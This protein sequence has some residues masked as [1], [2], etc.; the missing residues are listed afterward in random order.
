MSAE[1]LESYERSVV[2]EVQR[3]VNREPTWS[4]QLLGGM[5]DRS[6]EVLDIVLRTEWGRRTLRMATE[7]AFGAL[8]GVVLR[9]LADEGEAA[10][11][12]TDPQEREAVLRRADERAGELRSLYVG[13]LAAQ[14]ALVG[15]AS[16]TWARSVAAI[17]A[18]VALAVLVTL[19]ASAHH[20]AVYGVASSQPSVLQASVELVAVA[21]ESDPAVR[22]QQILVLSRGLRENRQAGDLDREL[23][24]V[25]IQQTSSRAVKEAVEHTVRRVMGG[26]MTGLVPV[27]GAAAGGAASGWLGAQVCDAA[28]QVGRVTFL[29]LHTPLPVNE[30][31]GI[32]P[33][34]AA[35][36]RTGVFR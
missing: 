14:G 8:E 7:R 4:D 27:L 35:T 30:V 16:L 22:K 3:W 17:V 31:L 33:E 28:R 13:A 25:V 36:S 12:P 6:R 15:A 20:L 2:D 34:V 1:V 5:S 26:R 10:L 29:A 18:D 21:T 11:V 23:P 24:R 9:G 19:R 32:G